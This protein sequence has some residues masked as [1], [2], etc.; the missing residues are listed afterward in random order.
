MK[1]RCYFASQDN[2]VPASVSDA[3][4]KALCI[5]QVEAANVAMATVIAEERAEAI[6]AAGKAGNK[7]KG[8]KKKQNPKVPPFNRRSC[9]KK[10]KFLKYYCFT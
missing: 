9:R 10:A 4:L 1:L 8:T 3:E 2:F 7:A 6:E 5:A